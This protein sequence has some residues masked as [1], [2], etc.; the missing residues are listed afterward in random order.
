MA[1]LL[2]LGFVLLAALVAAPASS[3]IYKWVDENGVVNYTNQAPANG[4]AKEL[5]LNSTRLSV[6]ETGTPQELEMLKVKSEVGY[7][8]QKVDQLE[9]QVESERYVGEYAAEPA[10]TPVE[11]EYLYPGYYYAP[12]YF[13]RHY[14]RRPR[15][16]PTRFI[17]T[18]RVPGHSFHTTQ[19]AWLQNQVV[20]MMNR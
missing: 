6:I 16:R 7:L 11:S 18:P 2:N 19:P 10:A 4:K 1:R 15:V 20:P 3:Q 9:S 12:G 5:D 13:I 17:N 14:P 8:R